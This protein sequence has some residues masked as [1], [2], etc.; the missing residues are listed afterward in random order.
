MG[1]LCF[2]KDSK[3]CSAKLEPSGF[4]ISS[5]YKLSEVEVT[6]K[7]ANRGATLGLEIPVNYFFSGD[8]RLITCVKNSL[9]KLNELHVKVKKCVK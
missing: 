5:V 8:A 9:E 7:R 4:Q 1:W 2:K 3:T 6:G